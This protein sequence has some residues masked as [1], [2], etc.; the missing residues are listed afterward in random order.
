[1]KDE[2]EVL[3]YAGIATGGSDHIFGF[4]GWAV[5]LVHLPRRLLESKLQVPQELQQKR[6]QTQFGYRETLLYWAFGR[7]MVFQD[8]QSMWDFNNKYSQFQRKWYH[9][10][11]PCYDKWR[12]RAPHFPCI[13]LD[14]K[15][16]TRAG[17]TEKSA[18]NSMPHIMFPLFTPD[19]MR[20]CH[21]LDLRKSKN[22][23]D[24]NNL[25]NLQNEFQEVQKLLNEVQNSVQ[26]LEAQKAQFQEELD[27]KLAEKSRQEQN[28]RISEL[29][30]KLQEISSQNDFQQQIEL[31]QQTEQFQSVSNEE[32]DEF[33]GS[34]N[35]SENVGKRRKLQGDAYN[36]VGGDVTPPPRAEIQGEEGTS[37][38]KKRSKEPKT[39]S[40]K[41]RLR[42][43]K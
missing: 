38:K 22:Q 43:S 16:M 23:I 26:N 20:R 32:I 25:I 27:L 7:L 10:A 6:Q 37:R 42:F 9:N 35:N 5:N 28:P 19:E 21:T 29:R 8:Y 15:K 31:S 24:Q 13:S 36:S 41:K 17:T 2:I 11:R 12:G 18:S 1:M 14:G 34:Q 4:V 39:N 3:R 33:T 30:Q 40:I